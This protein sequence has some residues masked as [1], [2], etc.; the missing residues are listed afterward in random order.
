MNSLHF[1]NRLRYQAAV[2]WW[3]EGNDL[4]SLHFTFK[5]QTEDRRCVSEC[6]EIAHQLFEAA[7]G[8]YGHLCWREEYWSK[9][10]IDDWTGRSG[11]PEGGRAQ[12]TDRKQHLPGVYWANFF[13]PVY[14]AFF[15]EDRLESAPAYEKRRGQ[16][17]WVLLTSATPDEWDAA[18]T[19]EREAAI[20]EHLGSDAFFLLDE[21]KRLTRAPTFVRV[22]NRRANTK[23]PG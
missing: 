3:S 23:G 2:M 13:G 17:S 15:G 8:Q 6:L 20:R 21:P 22:R 12:G 16:E 9:T 11:R 10:I 14:A 1:Q 18:E 5:I 19:V 4:D 7:N